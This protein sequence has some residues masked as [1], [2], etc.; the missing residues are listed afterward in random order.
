[1]TTDELLTRTRGLFPT[2]L[3][4]RLWLV[5]GT[6]RD[7]LLGETPG[8]LDLL[9]AV[10]AAELLP[11]GYRPVTPRS[12]APILFNFHRQ[13]GKIEITLLPDGAAGLAADLPRR[14]FTVNAMALSLAGKL[15]DPLDGQAALTGRQLVPCSPMA[16]SDDP[17]RIFRAFRFVAHGW[18]LS[19]AAA[20]LIG[21][22]DWESSLVG[23]PAERFSNEL[24]KALAG[25][26]PAD[27]FRLMVRFNVGHTFLPEL[28]RLAEVPAGPLRYHPEGDL[29]THAL[30]VLERF[31]AAEGDAAARFCAFTHDFGKLATPVDQYPRHIGHEEAGPAL[32]HDLCD[33]LRLP[34]ALRTAAMAI[35]RLHHVANHWP[36]LRPGTRLRLASDALKGRVAEFLPQMVAADKGAPRMDGWE[37]V[38]RIAGLSATE[39]GLD[40]AA[41]DTVPPDKR[42]ELLWQRRVA[43]VKAVSGER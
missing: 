37:G 19:P 21:E 31:A 29:L 14:D 32:V 18:Q 16:F 6:V 23:I 10:P 4:D 28:F 9:A 8:D 40:Q 7:L 11:L 15:I 34:A 12:A 20:D 42:A 43:L 13:W 27:F 24:L 26:A 30:Q 33:R 5:G 39:L 1:M 2:E 41:M 22:R 38:C 25:P 35:S 17:L 36:E 3:H